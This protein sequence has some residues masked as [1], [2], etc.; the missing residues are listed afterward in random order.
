MFTVDEFPGRS[1]TVKGKHFL[2]FGGTGYLGLQTDP[3]FQFLFIANIKKYGTGYSASRKSNIQLSIFEQA[4]SHL[5]NLVGSKDCITLS[6]GYLAGQLVRDYFD[7]TKY[8]LFY[9][10]NTHAA[11]YRGEQVLYPNWEDLE[12]EIKKNEHKIP[13]VLLDSYDF[14]GENYPDYQPLKKLP[15]HKVIVVVDDS[16]GIGIIGKKGEGSFKKLQSLK[17]RELLV[18]C[19]LGK[20]FG[21]Q[22]GAIFGNAERLKKMRKTQ[23]FGG[24][25]PASPA[26][27]ATLMD[28]YQ[29]Y[30]I[31]RKRLHQNTELFLSLLSNPSQFI[32][33]K[34]HPTFSFQNESLAKR[35]E[36]NGILVTNFRYPTEHDQPMSRIVISASHTAGDITTL[37]TFLNKETI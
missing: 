18:S 31:K 8:R 4:E 37:C 13:V 22:A 1:L 21:I 2:Y 35:L 28:A 25:G 16:H 30:S 10:P 29:L 19:S 27:L 32:Y 7:A 3:A 33:T 26:S 9:A 36:E 12:Q 24:S 20:G 6:S 5:A 23:F 15:L 14:Q 34:G 11:L 17:P